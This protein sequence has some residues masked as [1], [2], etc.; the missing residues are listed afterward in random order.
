MVSVK[1]TMTKLLGPPYQSLCVN[2]AD[3]DL[4]YFDHYTEKHC[5]YECSVEIIGIALQFWKVIFTDHQVGLVSPRYRIEVDEPEKL[6]SVAVGLHSSQLKWSFLCAVSS[7]T[8]N[9]YRQRFRDLFLIIEAI[10]YNTNF[11]LQIL[12]S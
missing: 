10:S 6:P 12:D 5:F 8:Q 1:Q 11:E 3:T 4:K 9:V 7:T 2:E